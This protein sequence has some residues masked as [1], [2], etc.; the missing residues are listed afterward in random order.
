MPETQ[1]EVPQPEA[2]GEQAPASAGSPSPRPVPPSAEHQRPARLERPMTASLRAVILTLGV[3]GV[4]GLSVLTGHAMGFGL[5]AS[6]MF[7]LPLGVVVGFLFALLLIL[8]PARRFA[9]QLKDF[10]DRVV[11]VSAADRDGGFDDLLDLEADHELVAI[12]QSVHA[13]LVSAHADRLEAARLRRE[14]D[15]RVNAQTRVNTAQLN[16]LST[17]DE[18]TG[19][20]NRRGFERALANMYTDCV[21]GGPELAV[22]AI[23]LD[24]FKRLN[25]T[26]GHDKGDLAL[27]AAGELMKAGIRPSDAAARVGGDELFLLIRG[28]KHD[29]AVAM[30]GRLADLFSRHASSKGLPWPT[31]SMGIALARAHHARSPEHLLQQADAALYAGK[32]AGRARCVVYDPALNPHAQAA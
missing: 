26:C 28:L 32:Q 10:S 27:K 13:A 14:M 1:P 5:R 22:V 3:A 21:G 19:L 15:A 8:L 4:T 12:A 24:H 25:D 7:A 17:T 9:A 2:T 23:D 20:L 30:A 18:L 29:K 31:M 11:R 16:R 6:V